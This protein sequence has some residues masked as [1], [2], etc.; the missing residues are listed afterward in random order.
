MK[1]RGLARKEERS[2]NQPAKGDVILGQV[3]FEE[4]LETL[5][6]RHE[7]ELLAIEEK[8]VSRVKVIMRKRLDQALD[9]AVA[10]YV[11]H[12]PRVHPEATNREMA[13]RNGLSVRE[14]KR[15]RRLARE[16]EITVQEAIRRRQENGPRY[17][18]A[19]ISGAD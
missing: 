2:H 10:E 16:Y 11:R 5:S 13:H 8:L 7:A 6:A 9:N 15:A 4:N 12:G 18:G 17:R 1:V 14:V 3:H 19:G